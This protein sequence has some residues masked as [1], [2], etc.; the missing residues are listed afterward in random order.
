[1]ILLAIP[2]IVL[3][4]LSIEL[5]ADS[6]RPW[7]EAVLR[8]ALL[9]G[10]VVVVITELLSIVGRLNRSW[11]LTG[12]TIVGLVILS[13]GYRRWSLQ[14]GWSRLRSMRLPSAPKHRALLAGT[15]AIALV[16]LLVAWAAPANTVDSLLYHMSRVAHWAQNAS[17]RP[18]AASY[19][20]QLFMPPWAE[21]A[22]LNL[23]LLSGSDRAS[24][25]VQ[26]SAMVGSLIGVSAIAARLGLGPRGRWLSVAF[27]ASIPM[28]I[29]QSTS[30][31]NDFVVAFWLICLAYFASAPRDPADWR[32]AVPLVGLSLGLGLLTKAT[33]YSY[34]APFAGWFLFSQFRSQPVRKWA[35]G[36]LAVLLI[37]AMLNSGYWVRNVITY[38]APF[39]PADWV[40][41]AVRIPGLDLRQP[42][43]LGARMLKVA[44]AAIE[45]PLTAMA[46]NLTTPS[47]AVNSLLGT[48]IRIVPLPIDEDFESTM[49]AAAWSHEDTA[50]SPVQ[51]LLIAASLLGLGGASLRR[52]SRPTAVT[53]GYVGAA[54]LGYWLMPMVISNGDSLDGL[55]FQLPFF[56]LTAPV[57]AAAVERLRRPRLSWS[58][59]AG[60][61]VFGLPW[62]LFNNTRPVIGHPPWPTRVGS[63]FAASRAEIMFAAVPHLREPLSEL[64][65]TMRQSN[66][67]SIGLRIDSSH[68]EYLFWWVLGAPESGV[69]LESM[70]T[71][72]QLARYLDPAFVPCAVVCTIC[73]DQSIVADLPLLRDWGFVRLYSAAWAYP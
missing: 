30:T 68:L 71:Y 70:N 59:A 20:H 37:A 24:N 43:S 7:Q 2:L 57:V 21:M 44:E 41:S 66:C 47:S 25:L 1:M 51:I 10:A 53:M 56:V 50:G 19:H 18:Y 8:A 45:R 17:L 22:I 65:T 26:W 64:A 11:T 15:S 13:T 35:F 55:R 52:K 67:R 4:L 34:A 63:V 72:P 46:R 6:D 5:A 9:I 27:A 54:T 60:L 62:L 32:R 23:R 40:G 49:Q 14:A 12:W 48:L 42:D 58:V 36:T 38:G 31:Q 16:C 39:G 28:G 29:L 33:A 73:D 3:A 69:R 61:L